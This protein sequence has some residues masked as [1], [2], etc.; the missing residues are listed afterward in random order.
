MQGR[1][2]FV[3]ANPWDAGSARLLA[4]L[5][6]EALATSSGAAAG[7]L[8]RRDGQITRD[9]ALAHARAIVDASPAAGLGRPRERL[10][11]TSRKLRPRRSVGRR[12]RSGRRLDRGRDRRRG[13]AALRHRPR[14]RAR[15]G[16]RGGRA[17]VAIPLHA[18][19][20]RRELPARQ[21][22]PRRHDPAPAGVREGRRRRA[23]R[24]R[25]A[26]P[27][28]GARGLRGA[29]EAGQLH[30]RHHGASRSA[31]PS[32]RRLAC[33]ASASRPRSTAPR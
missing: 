20:A 18:D 23:V 27:R 6:F 30:G 7:V 32:S 26:R 10:R 4:G 3:I 9:E 2:A 25:P 15:R 14:D 19:R 12:G 33:G 22:G 28:G 8:G 29:D 1:G 16:R 5:G 31:S 13:A 24:A 21:P 17:I 11:P